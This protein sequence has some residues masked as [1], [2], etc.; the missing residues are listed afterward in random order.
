MTLRALTL[1]SKQGELESNCSRPCPVKFWATSNDG[2]STVSLES[3]STSL[4]VTFFITRISHVA[5]F[6]YYLLLFF[7]SEE[8]GFTFSP[9]SGSWWSPL[10]L[11]NMNKPCRVPSQSLCSGHCWP[12]LHSHK[13]L[14]VLGSLKPYMVV[15]VCFTKCETERNNCF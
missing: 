6:A 5:T 3:F 4:T 13:H 8:S 11:L 12:T 1:C 15:Q 10:G 7:S 9:L 14:C 2:D